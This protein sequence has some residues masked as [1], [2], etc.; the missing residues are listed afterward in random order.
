MAIEFDSNIVLSKK[1][2]KNMF[3]PTLSKRKLNTN[4]KR[5]KAIYHR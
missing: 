5:G 3:R 4:S 2:E 1:E